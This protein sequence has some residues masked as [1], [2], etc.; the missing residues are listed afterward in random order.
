MALDQT[1][2]Y[3]L[4]PNTEP[5]YHTRFVVHRIMKYCQMLTLATKSP[6]EKKST[7]HAPLPFYESNNNVTAYASKGQ[8]LFLVEIGEA[9]S[10]RRKLLERHDR[11]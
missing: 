3:F 5:F 10:Q 4:S 1:C 6:K 8:V 7:S 2:R 11:G 9:I